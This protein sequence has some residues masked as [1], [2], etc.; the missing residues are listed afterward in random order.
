MLVVGKVGLTYKA[1]IDL[2]WPSQTG[3]VPVSRLS[4]SNRQ[5]L[6]ANVHFRVWS[7]K[8][9]A[10]DLH[11]DQRCELVKF[12]GDSS[13][14]LV[15]VNPSFDKV[16]SVK[17]FTQGNYFPTHNMVKFL[18]KASSVGMVP[19]NWLDPMYLSPGKFLIL[20]L[21]KERFRLTYKTVKFVSCPSCVGMVPLNWLPYKPLL[22]TDWLLDCSN[23][24]GK[25]NLQSH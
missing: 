13:I 24:D 19:V 11:R 12:R 14:E 1:V 15:V 18:R 17:N 3:M 4:K 8:W 10:A 7:A 5:I 6:L 21:R 9:G 16:V 22:A 20:V 25:G 2:R 23:K